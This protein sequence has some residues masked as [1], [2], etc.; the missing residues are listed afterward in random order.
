M[1]TLILITA[2]N[3]EKIIEKVILRL[4][5]ELKESHLNVEILIIDDASNDDTLKKIIS[6]RDKYQEYKITCLS[7][8]A[9][10]GYGGNQKIGYYYAIKN[11]FDYVVLLHGDGQYAP[12]YLPKLLKKFD[13]N[14][15]CAAVFGSRMIKSGS[16]LSGGMP[17]YK[18]FGNKILTLIQ[19]ILLT[20]KLSEFHSGYRAYKV[21]YLKKIHFELNSNDYNFDT[22]IIIQ[23]ILSKMKI[24]EI[25]IPTFY[26][27]EISYV[28]GLKY[29][30]QIVFESLKAKLHK[31]NIINEIKF[32]QVENKKQKIL[33]NKIYS[34]FNKMINSSKQY[35]YK[36]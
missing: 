34:N 6:I 8:K 32:N 33:K 16:A 3:V 12:E 4:P 26:G 17:L 10:L 5:K 22:Q 11:N 13:E 19:N 7:N 25:P 15:Y 18:F 31:I 2:F 24:V 30:I 23:L 9:N 14:S 1:K 27:D 21:S 29:A 28:N 20:S 36:K 35:S